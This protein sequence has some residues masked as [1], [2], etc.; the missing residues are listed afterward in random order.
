M[1]SF[2]LLGYHCTEFSMQFRVAE[3]FDNPYKLTLEISLP[4]SVVLHDN[5]ECTIYW[6]DG[7]VEG[8]VKIEDL[9]MQINHTYSSARLFGLF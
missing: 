7:G 3:P 8:P 5:P 6:A 1:Y 4:G 9:P 2:S